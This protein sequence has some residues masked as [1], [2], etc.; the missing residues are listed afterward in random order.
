MT[1]R[2]SCYR[3][4]F[5]GAEPSRFFPLY[6]GVMG[7][8][9]LLCIGGSFWRGRGM[10]ELTL[11]I[12]GLFALDYALRLWS[13]VERD[14]SASPGRLRWRY[15]LSPLGLLDLLSFLPGFISLL[16][17]LNLHFL[18]LVRILVLFKVLLRMRTLDIFLRV[19]R[20]E[21]LTLLLM[22]ATVLVLIL[23]AGIGILSLEQE[24]Q[25]EMFASLPDAMWWALVTMTTVGYGD[26]YPVTLGGRVLAGAIMLLGVGTVALPAGLLAAAFSEELAHEREARR[27]RAARALQQGQ[28]PWRVRR[29]LLVLS[30]HLH[31]PPEELLASLTAPAATREPDAEPETAQQPGTPWAYC[32]H[33]GES[34][35]PHDHG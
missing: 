19:L 35:P 16:L 1:R 21:A 2:Q 32:P 28:L 33:C 20:K 6:N 17:P 11:A 14:A 12:F 23:M 34:L 4:L 22:I 26:M 15:A 13:C 8:L 25:P 30:R 31:V 18:R 9:V 29:S 10:G 27:N 5:G 24:A 3:V 7:L